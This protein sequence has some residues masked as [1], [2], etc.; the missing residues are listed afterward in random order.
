[1]GKI[2]FR[3]VPLDNDPFTDQYHIA[4]VAER[5]GRL[6]TVT[7]RLTGPL[8]GLDIEPVAD[9]P[10]RKDHLWQETCFECFVSAAHTVK[11]WEINL[12]PARHWNIYRFD[13][14]RRGMQKERAFSRLVVSTDSITDKLELSSRLALAPIGLTR[15]PIVL[16]ISA[17]LKRNNGEL[18]YWALNHYGPQPDFHRREGFALTL[19]KEEQDPCQLK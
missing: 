14:Y 18:T 5:T 1:M 7:Y 12:S 9:R 16:A 19:A 15:H 6:L 8:Q 11:Y 10:L 3:L 17:V 2:D 13:D 4:G